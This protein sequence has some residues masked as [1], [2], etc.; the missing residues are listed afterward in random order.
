MDRALLKKS[1]LKVKDNRITGMV[2]PL[3][4]L[5]LLVVV[6]GS[7]TGG[8]FFDPFNLTLI[9]N[10]SLI[11]AT[12]ATGAV[13]I[14]ATGNVNLAMGATAGLITAIA[15]EVYIFTES[16]ALM[17][18][19][20][21]VAGVVISVIEVIISSKF[22]VKVLF[23]TVVMMTLLL[24]LQQTVLDNDTVSIPYEITSA[25]QDSGFTYIAFALY[26]VMCFVIFN[27]TRVGRSVKFIG[28]NSD[29]STVTGIVNDRYLMIAFIISGI[30]AALGA[31]M[32]ITRSGS[33][34]N[35]TLNTMNMDVLLAIVLGGM[36]VFGGSK[37]Y[38]YSATLGAITV[39]VL[40]NGFTLLQVDNIWLQGVRG[41]FFL[42]LV[43]VSQT[44]TGLLPEKD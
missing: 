26:F 1:L 5:F 40:N 22:K 30:G 19:T 11:V 43:I 32:T 29:C 28:T 13:F 27:F 41:L 10:Q 39:V 31:L 12:I 8:R 23:V 44:R 42:I 36:S 3:I 9:I 35:N 33:V 2:M 21:L 34:N 18:I 7:S 37:S 14:Y 38:I 20:A 24:A 17:F 4:W 6:F 15:A 25:L 16:V